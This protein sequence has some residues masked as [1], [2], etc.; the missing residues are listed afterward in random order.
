VVPRLA[1]NDGQLNFVLFVG[2]VNL[3]VFIHTQEAVHRAVR[4]TVACGCATEGLGCTRAVPGEANKEG[5]VEN[6]REEQEKGD[7][8]LSGQYGLAAEPCCMAPLLLRPAACPEKRNHRRCGAGPARGMG[9]ASWTP[10]ASRR[11]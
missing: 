9:L 8:W 4:G 6:C 11:P 2:I 10:G 3:Q 5:T 1:G 7:A